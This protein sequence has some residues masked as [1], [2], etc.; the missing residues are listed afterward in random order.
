[1]KVDMHT[2]TDTSILYVY[3]TRFPE[4]VR[5]AEVLSHSGIVDDWTR[6]MILIYCLG[7]GKDA[8]QYINIIRARELCT[9]VCP[10]SIEKKAKRDQKK[11]ERMK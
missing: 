6:A 3:T 4:H 11:K 5:S 9:V 7:S 10:G 2:F 1:M 8:R